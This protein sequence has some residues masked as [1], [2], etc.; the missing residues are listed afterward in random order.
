MD[1]CFVIASWIEGSVSRWG[2]LSLSDDDDPTANLSPVSD[3]PRRF[4]SA[5]SCFAMVPPRGPGDAGS[6][7]QVQSCPNVEYDK[8]M[9]LPFPAVPGCVQSADS[10]ARHGH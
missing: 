9:A 6:A 4:K 8:P 3:R 2:C 5:F 7:D 10:S 1:A